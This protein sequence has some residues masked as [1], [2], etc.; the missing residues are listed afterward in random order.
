[1]SSLIIQGSILV[2]FVLVV[3]VVLDDNYGFVIHMVAVLSSKD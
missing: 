3:L 1:M 2:E